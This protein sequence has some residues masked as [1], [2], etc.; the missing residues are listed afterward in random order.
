MSKNKKEQY[1]LNSQVH[2]GSLKTSVPKGT[3]IVVD[4]KGKTVEIN[5]VPHDNIS[6]VDLGIKAGFIIPYIE[7]K[8]EVDSTV[9]VSKKVQ[10]M[11]SKK[12]EVQKSDMDVMPKEID[13]SDTKKDVREA[14]RKQ[15]RDEKKFTVS[16]ENHDDNESRG[17]KVVTNQATGLKADTNEEIMTI[18]NGD[19]DMREI[20]KIAPKTA[21]KKPFGLASN[22]DAKDDVAEQINGQGTVVKKIGKGEAETKK[23]VSGK[24]LV[25]KRPKE[26]GEGVAKAAADARKREI[27]AKR[28]QSKESK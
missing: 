3:I 21:A 19:S 17:L 6:D 28:A 16:Y 18:V 4:R 11:Q 9:R 1:I 10:E 2:F 5:G 23:V 26:G 24:T 15:E 14:K 7:G 25:T 13:I 12:M 20:G 27:A 22:E 8:T